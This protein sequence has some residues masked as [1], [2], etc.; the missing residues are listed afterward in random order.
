MAPVNNWLALY[1]I[2]GIENRVTPIVIVFEAERGDAEV[3]VK[4]EVVWY[5]TGKS[6]QRDGEKETNA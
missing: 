2:L 3:P 4:L 6:L 5:P 1:G